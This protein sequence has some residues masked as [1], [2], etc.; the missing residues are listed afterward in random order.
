VRV[1][2][3]FKESVVANWDNSDVLTQK[4]GACNTLV[5]MPNGNLYGFNTDAAGLTSALEQRLPLRQ[6]KVLVL[7]A[8]GAGRAAVFGLKERGAEV[9]IL[10]RTP[11]AAQKLARQAH[12][13]FIKRTDLKK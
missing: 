5:R 7:G 3:P 8:G 12:A 6:A 9:Y 10:N 1:T 13:R 11:A 4:S 2:M